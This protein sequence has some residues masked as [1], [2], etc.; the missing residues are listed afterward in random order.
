MTGVQTCALPISGLGSE[1][2]WADGDARFSAG[3][4][5]TA[6]RDAS[7]R[8]VYD[9][10]SGHLYYDADGAGGAGAQLLLTLQGAP[11]LSASDIT[12]I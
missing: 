11:A 7:D 8:L 3:A 9:T 1:G 2:T 10:A 5:A 12:V 4:G 6:A